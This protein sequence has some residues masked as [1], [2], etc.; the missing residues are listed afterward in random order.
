MIRTWDLPPVA[1]F[2]RTRNAATDE[3]HP[4]RRP[5]VDYRSF[6]SHRSTDRRRGL[7]IPPPPGSLNLRPRKNTAPAGSSNPAGACVFIQPTTLRP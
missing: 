2:R 7:P 1:F 6:E 3:V 5:T 4:V